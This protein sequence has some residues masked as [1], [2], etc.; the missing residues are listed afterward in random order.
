VITLEAEPQTATVSD[1]ATGEELKVV[2]DGGALVDWIRDQSRT[3]TQLTRVP[4]LLDELA[5]GSPEAL[6]AIAMYRIQLA[7]PPSPG[8]PSTSYGLGYGVV[9]REQFASREDI[10]DA[11]RQAFPLYPASIQDQ[12]VG[13][14]A[15]NNDDCSRVWKVPVAPAEVRRPVVSSIPTVLISGSFDAVASL[16][17]TESVAAGLSK[18]TIISIPGIGH[19]VLPLSTCAQSVVAS[20]LADPSS[21]D[22]S[23]VSALKPPPFTPFQ[24][25]GVA[26]AAPAIE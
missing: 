4:A 7:P 26:P 5:H 16:D 21:P 22:T 1:P 6:A 15:Y 18:A 14:W 3:N 11:G 10:S 12:A 8:V 17:F 25:E 13:T 9:C 20:F 19:F 2:V 23:C 24:P